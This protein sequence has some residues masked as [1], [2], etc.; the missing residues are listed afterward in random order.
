M[1]TDTRIDDQVTRAVALREQGAD[2]EARSALLALVAEHPDH[3]GA[4]LQCAWT[5]DKLGLEEE[6]VPF[7]ERAIEL[8]LAPEDLEPALLGLGS[9]LRALGRYPESLE[10]LD[11]AV[12]AFPENN[13][14]EVFRAISRYNNGLAKEA[15]ETLLRLLI[16]TTSDSTIRLYQAALDIYAEDLDRTWQ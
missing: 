5:H 9:T 13:A 4:N 7:Y 1:T 6:A 10:V 14:L 16:A 3:P 2:E 8:G 15:T 11:R 12:A